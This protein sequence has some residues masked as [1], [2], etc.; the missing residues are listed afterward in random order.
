RGAGQNISG[1]PWS[2]APTPSRVGCDL[3]SSHLDSGFGIWDSGFARSWDSGFGTRDSQAA[4]STSTQQT[5]ALGTRNSEPGTPEP[6]TQNSQSARQGH[7]LGRGR[8]TVKSARMFSLV[9]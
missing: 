1:Q 5:A 8:A 2:R 9:A 4:L 6:G 7:N 3:C